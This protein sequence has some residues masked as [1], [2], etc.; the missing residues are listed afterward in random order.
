MSDDIHVEIDPQIT[1]AD[2]TTRSFH[3]SDLF[4]NYG[5]KQSF[6]DTMVPLVNLVAST[7]PVKD[8]S[9]T[10]VKRRKKQKQQKLARKITRQFSNK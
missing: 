2:G 3:P 5:G 1:L 4:S 6:Y 8:M 9:P 7:L 10:V